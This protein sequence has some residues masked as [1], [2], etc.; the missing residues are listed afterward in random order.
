M[1]ETG[2]SLL[3]EVECTCREGDGRR[4]KTQLGEVYGEKT[5]FFFK[6]AQKHHFLKPEPIPLFC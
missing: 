1:E 4:Y 6:Q 5:Q 3:L 2:V